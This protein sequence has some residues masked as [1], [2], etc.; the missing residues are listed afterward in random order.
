MEPIYARKRVEVEPLR[1]CSSLE[2]LGNKAL[3][4]K[5]VNI[6]AADY[7]LSD[8]R[9]YYEG[10]V[11][12]NGRGREGAKN[13]ELLGIVRSKTDFTETDIVGRTNDII[14]S[15]VDFMDSVGLIG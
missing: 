12:G 14:G 13:V 9:K 8:K 7:R 5:R 11:D 3:L 15:F 6:R 4:E 10:F 2:A 1:D